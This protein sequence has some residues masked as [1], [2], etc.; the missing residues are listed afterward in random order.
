[1][2]SLSWR[3]NAAIASFPPSSRLPSECPNSMPIDV[4]KTGVPPATVRQRALAEDVEVPRFVHD[5]RSEEH[6]HFEVL[7]ADRRQPL[8]R[9]VPRDELYFGQE[10]AELAVCALDV[11][12][13]RLQLSPWDVRRRGP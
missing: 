2:Y 10:R 4:P 8:R 7:V 13:Q 3:R 9:R 1:M 11:V 6:L 12:R 5:L